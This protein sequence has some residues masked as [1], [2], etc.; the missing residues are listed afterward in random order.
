MVA[1]GSEG[2]Y[3]RLIGM[4]GASRT[5]FTSSRTTRGPWKRPNSVRSRL[6]RHIDDNPYKSTARR[7]G[8]A[9]ERD[10]C[11]AMRPGTTI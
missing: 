8:A 3:V 5:R 11:D 6:R 2:T 4:C 7:K 10:T 1:E 9:R